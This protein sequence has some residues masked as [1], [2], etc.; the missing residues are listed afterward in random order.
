[1][2]NVNQGG[3]QL[4]VGAQEVSQETLIAGV[5]LTPAHQ[6]LVELEPFVRIVATL[7]FANA[8][9]VLKE[10]QIFHAE[11]ILVPVTLVV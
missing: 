1:M 11:K 3:D 8:H 7:L 5:R 2:L 9:Q 6:I 10:T 4:F